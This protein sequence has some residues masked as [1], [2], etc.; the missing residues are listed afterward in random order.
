M[1]GEEREHMNLTGNNRLSITIANSLLH[2][3]GGGSYQNEQTTKYIHVT[4]KKL[5]ATLAKGGRVVVYMFH[6]S[7]ISPDGHRRY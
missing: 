6:C 4:A 1:V 2:R 5:S 3:R 7:R